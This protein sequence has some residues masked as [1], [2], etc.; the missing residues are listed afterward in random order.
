MPKSSKKWGKQTGAE[1]LIVEG[2]KSW[3][4][5]KLTTGI[6]LF[7]TLDSHSSG[8]WALGMG[9][10]EETKVFVEGTGTFVVNE[11]KN[12]EQTRH[13]CFRK[14]LEQ[15]VT[16]ILQSNSSLGKI[17]VKHHRNSQKI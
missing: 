13:L 10:N 5:N 15:N 12:M 16:Y 8:I 11:W 4:A 3:N 9:E 6:K 14:G 2:R 1:R 7:R 17:S